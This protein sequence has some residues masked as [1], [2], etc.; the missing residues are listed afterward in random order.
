MRRARIIDL[1]EIAGVFRPPRE[2]ENPALSRVV[3][4]ASRLL[5]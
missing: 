5:D 3:R 2:K 4:I 1:T